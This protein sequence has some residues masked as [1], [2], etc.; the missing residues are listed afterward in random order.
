MGLYSSYF[1]ILTL[2]TLSLIQKWLLFFLVPRRY[3]P[4]D[5]TYQGVKYGLENGQQKQVNT[6]L[7]VANR[8]SCNTYS[9]QEKKRINLWVA[10]SQKEAT[11][12]I[13]A[14]AAAA[15][16]TPT[17]IKIELYDK[18]NNTRRYSFLFVFVF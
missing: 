11:K 15:A 14:A 3:F 13:A 8:M 2:L 16:S 4:T 12:P 1:H 9:E 18:L 7:T 6:L 5:L 17:I 10:N